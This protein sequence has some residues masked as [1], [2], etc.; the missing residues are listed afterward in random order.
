MATFCIIRVGNILP[1]LGIPYATPALL[2]H[3]LFPSISACPG[4]DC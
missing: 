3:K 1:F 2:H 4:P